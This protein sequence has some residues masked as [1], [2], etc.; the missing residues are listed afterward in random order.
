M[1]IPWTRQRI[2]EE[3]N[4]LGASIGRRGVAVQAPDIGGEFVSPGPRKFQFNEA[5]PVRGTRYHHHWGNTQMRGGG[6]A[7]NR[8]FPL[9][10]RSST[11]RAITG[12]IP[13]C[14][15]QS[16]AVP[17]TPMLCSLVN[18]LL[19]WARHSSPKHPTYPI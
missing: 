1:G 12:P 16:E 9:A 19:Y 17:G 2:G 8:I 15:H 4:V 3:V 10:T 13:A 6:G 18:D 5:M 7:G 14:Y 11:S